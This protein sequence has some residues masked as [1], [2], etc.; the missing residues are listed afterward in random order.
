MAQVGFLA[1]EAS[2]ALGAAKKKQNKKTPKSQ[3]HI[4]PLQCKGVKLEKNGKSSVNFF[5][6]F[7][8]LPVAYGSS[9]AKG[10]IRAAAAGP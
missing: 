2:H 4:N 6:F 9:Q 10:Q 8:A 1:Q 3:T 5:F 7:R